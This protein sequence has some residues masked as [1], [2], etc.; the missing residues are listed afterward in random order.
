MRSGII[1][2]DWDG[3]GRLEIIQAGHDGHLHQYRADGTEV[4]TGN[5]PIQVRVPDSIPITRPALNNPTDTR[6][7]IRMQDFR[8]SSRA[9]LLVLNPTTGET[10]TLTMPAAGW[11]QLPSGFRYS[12]RTLAR[13]PV[14][15]PVIGARR[16][17]K[18]LATGSGIG[19]TLDEPA[20]GSLGVVFTTGGRRYCTLFGGAVRRDVPGR[21]T[22]VKAPPPPVC[23]GG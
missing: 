12:D 4:R 8:I 22:A 14:R 5:W 11:T 9:S 2:A 15:K 19:F 21:F 18:V 23:P 3:D 16:L 17:A 13:G 20:Q 1:L 6:T 7:P 10:A